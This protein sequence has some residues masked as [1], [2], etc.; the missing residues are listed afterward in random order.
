MSQRG[1]FHFYFFHTKTLGGPV[2]GPKFCH[3]KK[4]LVVMF[5]HIR[6]H[7]RVDSDTESKKKGREQLRAAQAL[8]IGRFGTQ[9]NSRGI[10]ALMTQAHS[11]MNDESTDDSTRHISN[12]LL[13]PAV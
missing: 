12:G 5:S 6:Q 7:E 9:L 1:G 8:F 4:T 11:G 3:N 2:R 13:P 10:L